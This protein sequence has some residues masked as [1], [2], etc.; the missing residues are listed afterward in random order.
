VVADPVIALG[1]IGGGDAAACC[2]CGSTGVTGSLYVT[3]VSSASD[4][5]AAAAAA[6]VDAL[7]VAGLLLA[8]PLAAGLVVARFLVA[9]PAVAAAECLVTGELVAV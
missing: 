8:G 7:A 3:E 5:S 9:R 6:A 4:G 1:R 2:V